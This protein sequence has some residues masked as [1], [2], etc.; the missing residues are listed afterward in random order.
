MSEGKTYVR[1]DE[2]GVLRVGDSRVMLDSVLAGF[3]QGY[4]PE[5]I[6]QQYPALR[7]EEVYGAIAYYLAHQDEVNTYLRRQDALWEQG[8]AKSQEN[9][10]PVVERLRALRRAGAP[11]VS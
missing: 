5:T 1:V 10:N 11:E 2:Y 9:P 4:S 7:L 8:R 6:H 3:Q